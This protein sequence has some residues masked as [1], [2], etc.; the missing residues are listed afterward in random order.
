M[1]RCGRVRERLN[2]YGKWAQA[3]LAGLWRPGWRVVAEVEQ[4]VE[5]EWDDTSWWGRAY[6]L[7]LLR[8]Y[9]LW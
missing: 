1:Q 4:V 3:A 8:R 9:T 5:L 2:H 7:L 6:W